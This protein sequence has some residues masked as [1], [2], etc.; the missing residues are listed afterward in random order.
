MPREYFFQKKKRSFAQ[1][2]FEKGLNGA[3]YILLALSEA[4]EGFLRDL[5][6]SYPQFKLM[7]DLFGVD[8][9]GR[10]IKRETI[11]VNLHRLKKQGLIAQEPKEK[12]YFLTDKG[13]EFVSYIKNRFL[14]LKQPWDGKLRVVIFDIPEKKKEWRKWLREELD[15][16]QFHQLQKSVYIGKHPL[17]DSFYKAVAKN[18][19]YNYVFVLTAGEIDKKEEI[20]EMFKK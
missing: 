7:K 8:Y 10:K 12:Y 17:P 1:K 13:E 4:G 14:I 20:L 15:L 6:S 18:G 19:L 16:M 9:R 2:F 11:K 3:S 5:P